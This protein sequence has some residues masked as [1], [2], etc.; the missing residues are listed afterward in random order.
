[1]HSKGCAPVDE[2]VVESEFE[3][4]VTQLCLDLGSRVF[5]GV[6][7]RSKHAQ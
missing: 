6:W 4:E 5:A 7:V 2:G 3:D 1:M